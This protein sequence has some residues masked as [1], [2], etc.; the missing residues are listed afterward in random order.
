MQKKTPLEI[1]AKFKNEWNHNELK[2]ENGKVE[3]Y[4]VNESEKH[5]LLYPY[6][7]NNALSRAGHPID[8]I[9]EL[10]GTTM[11]HLWCTGLGN[12][13]LFLKSFKNFPPSYSDMPA[14]HVKI[15]QD[16]TLLNHVVSVM[17]VGVT[18]L[19]FYGEK[20]K[21]P[22]SLK[23]VVSILEENN[24]TNLK[25][26]LSGNGSKTSGKYVYVLEV[27]SIEEFNKFVIANG[28]NKLNRVANDSKSKC[29]R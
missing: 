29:L 17:P 25:F 16:K 26:F 22:E 2:S 11:I 19:V 14:G 27:P 20:L 4:F 10:N 1:F 18:K 8:I 28:N 12:D 13:E 3:F 5:P 15:L 9:K 24:F 6:V 23:Q 7:V 21:T